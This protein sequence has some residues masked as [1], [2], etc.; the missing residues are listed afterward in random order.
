MASRV[1]SPLAVCGL[2]TLLRMRFLPWS[3]PVRRRERS[4]WAA[5][6]SARSIRARSR[7]SALCSRSR[8]PAIR[9]R[10]PRQP[11]GGRRTVDALEQGAGAHRGGRRCRQ[12]RARCRS[13]IARQ[14]A[15]DLKS[16]WTATSTDARLKKRIVRTII[17]EVIADIDSEAVEIVLILHW[18]GGVHTEMRLPRRR[19]GQRSST[20]LM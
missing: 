6:S 9:R 10:R 3:A 12:G 20:S 18:I 13:S 7:S 19:R 11:A 8:L 16:V 15:A 14:L 4:Q 1:A 17:L 2:M 5:R